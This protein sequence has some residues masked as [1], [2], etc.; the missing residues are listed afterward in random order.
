MRKNRRFSVINS[1]TTGRPTSSIRVGIAL[2][3]GQS[4]HDRWYDFSAVDDGLRTHLLLEPHGQATMTVPRPVPCHAENILGVPLAVTVAC[5]A[6][7]KD[8]QPTV[9]REVRGMTHVSVLST[10][11]LEAD[12]PLPAGF[13]PG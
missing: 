6:E 1:Q 3:R 5:P 2:R 13:H 12:D 7:A 11:V 10:L 9:S 4:V 8:G